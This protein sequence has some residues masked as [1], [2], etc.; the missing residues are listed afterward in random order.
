MGEG[1]GEAGASAM[2]SRFGVWSRSSIR[3]TY[4]AAA[5]VLHICFSLNSLTR[6]RHWLSVPIANQSAVELRIKTA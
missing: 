3:V 6:C 5:A 4:M 1:D 2:D